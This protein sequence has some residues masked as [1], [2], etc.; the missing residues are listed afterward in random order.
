MGRFDLFQPS[1]HTGYETAI[2]ID[3]VGPARIAAIVDGVEVGALRIEVVAAP[4]SVSLVFGNNPTPTSYFEVASL[5]GT[6]GGLPVAGLI[7]E[8]TA[9]PPNLLQITDPHGGEVLMQTGS[10][11]GLVTI[12]ATLADRMVTASLQITGP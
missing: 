12:T 11:S 6:A 4:D 5:V 10:K 3:S 9:D 7:G 1:T 8:F 2:Q